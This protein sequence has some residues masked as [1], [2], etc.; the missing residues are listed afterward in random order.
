MLHHMYTHIYVY[1]HNYICTHDTYT[2]C[3]HSYSVS[4][5]VCPSSTSHR[6]KTQAS[7]D[8][9]SCLGNRLGLGRSRGFLEKLV[10]VG[11]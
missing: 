3:I 11:V 2:L 4:P 10:Y 5:S 6:M 9:V 7:M 1:I 8:Q